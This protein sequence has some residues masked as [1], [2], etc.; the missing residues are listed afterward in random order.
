MAGRDRNQKKL[1]SLAAANSPLG[2]NKSGTCETLVASPSGIPARP[3]VSF[4]SPDISANAAPSR[5]Q[6]VTLTAAAGVNQRKLGPLD[7]RRQGDSRR[8]KVLLP[9]V[10]VVSGLDNNG[11]GTTRRSWRSAEAVNSLPPTRHDE[12][13]VGGESDDATSASEGSTIKEIKGKR[14]RRLVPWNWIRKRK[15]GNTQQHLNFLQLSK[16]RMI[17]K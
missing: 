2:E 7:R 3:S 13:I 12:I 15:G 11:G 5:S 14:N 1:I 16:V 8:R 6:S 9:R 17:F 4:R 10:S